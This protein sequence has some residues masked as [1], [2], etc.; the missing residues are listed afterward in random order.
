MTED[1]KDPSRSEPVE[2]A[3]ATTNPSRPA[4]DEM[5]RLHTAEG[6]QV[7][8]SREDW[9][10]GTLEPML[11]AQWDN[12]DGLY[13]NCVMSL[14]DGFAREPILLEAA[15]RLHAIDTIPER[16][17]TILGIV[18]WKSGQLAEARALFEAS[19]QQYPE[20]GNL[21]NNLAKVM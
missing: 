3:S 10:T 16:G 19:L 13:R 17:M 14:N 2:E 8:V 15:Q 7:L 11:R 9:R 6:L 18:L 20:S 12:P 1:S 21:R 5:V 4:G